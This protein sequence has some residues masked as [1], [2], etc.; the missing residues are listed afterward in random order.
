[1]IDHLTPPLTRAGA[2]GAQAALERLIDEYGEASRLD[3]RRLPSL[4]ASILDLA[5]KAGLDRE[6]GIADNDDANAALPKLDGLLCELKE[7]QIRD[8]LHVFGRVPPGAMPAM[9][10]GLAWPARHRSGCSGRR[11]AAIGLRGS[12]TGRQVLSTC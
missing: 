3:P 2:Y 5:R 11:R 4:G 12:H 7:H 8:G 6:C 10:S 1:V 9:I